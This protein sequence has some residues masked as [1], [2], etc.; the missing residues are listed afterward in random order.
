MEPTYVVLNHTYHRHFCAMMRK[1]AENLSD[2]EKTQNFSLL[3]LDWVAGNPKDP[4]N[5]KAAAPTEATASSDL[6]DEDRQLHEKVAAMVTNHLRGIQLN[7]PELEWSKA[8]IYGDWVYHEKGERQYFM[9]IQVKRISGADDDLL[10]KCGIDPK[11]V[12]LSLVDDGKIEV[13]DMFVNPQIQSPDLG[14]PGPSSQTMRASSPVPPPSQGKAKG[15]LPSLLERPLNTRKPRDPSKSSDDEA[16][17]KRLPKAPEEPLASVTA[18]VSTQLVSFADKGKAMAV[19]ADEGT[20]SDTSRFGLDSSR[21]ECELIAPV[22]DMPSP[23]DLG[24]PTHGLPSIAS[25]TAFTGLRPLPPPITAPGDDTETSRGHGIP[26]ILPLVLPNSPSPVSISPPKSDKTIASSP[27]PPDPIKTSA[28]GEYISCLSPKQW[29]IRER[30]DALAASLASDPVF[31]ARKSASFVYA[32]RV[33]AIPDASDSNGLT[34]PRTE[35]RDGT[36]LGAGGWVVPPLTERLTHRQD[37]HRRFYAAMEETNGSHVRPLPKPQTCRAMPVD[38]DS[39]VADE[40]PRSFGEAPPVWREL[41]NPCLEDVYAM[42]WALMAGKQ[43]VGFQPGYG[44]GIARLC[45]PGLFDM[46]AS[47]PFRSPSL[48]ALQHSAN[49]NENK[50]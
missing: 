4:S 12:F 48:E 49:W 23:A 47:S 11:H 9:E 18:E 30:R 27:V 31:Q 32:V 6:S 45:T 21:T 25:I 50:D 38:F 20:S 34:G 42:T 10:G 36:L 40:K 19:T 5:I 13:S 29:A 46:L 7:D 44:F 39:T 2:Y 24:I 35:D 17:K 22:A 1:K 16:A 33:V 37:H 8:L 26:R 14:V 15:L 41:V 3:H 28:H 43:Y